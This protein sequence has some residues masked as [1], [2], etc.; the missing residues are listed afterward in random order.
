MN[1]KT[2]KVLTDRPSVV[3][4]ERQTPAAWFRP[5]LLDCLKDYNR[6]KFFADLAAGLTVGVVALPLAMAYALRDTGCKAV[7]ARR[8]SRDEILNELRRVEDLLS[9]GEKL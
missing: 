9:R 6:T 2:A 4:L 7:I 5:K 3:E 1:P 8:G